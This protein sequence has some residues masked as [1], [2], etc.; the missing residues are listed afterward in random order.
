SPD[1]STNSLF[2]APCPGQ[3]VH[4]VPG[5]VW[6]TYAYH[7]HERRTMAWTLEGIDGERVRLRAKQCEGVL[8]SELEHNQGNCMECERLLTSESLARFVQQAKGDALPRTPW[9]YLNHYQSSKLMIDMSKRISRLYKKLR[10]TQKMNERLKSK[11]DDY[12]RLIML[13]SQH[14]IGGV[15]TILEIGIRNGASP[16]ALYAKLERAINGLYSPRS[17]WTTREFDIAFLATA[18]GGARLLYVFQKADSYPSNA[19]LKRRKPIPEL[20]VSTGIPNDPE[21]SQNLT[22]I[23]GEGG[24]RAP[25]NPLIGQTLMIDG[26]ALEEACRYDHQRGCI[27]GICREHAHLAPRGLRVQDYQHILDLSDSLYDEP[28]ACHHGK[29]G[30]VL[31]LAPVTGTK[32]YYPTP[33]L[34][35]PSCKKETGDELYDW[36]VRFLNI[37]RDHLDGEKKHGPIFTLATDGESSF[38]SMRYRLGVS[39]M[40]DIDSPMGQIV[41]HLPGFNCFT[42]PNGI[43]TTSDPKHIV[44]RFA[45]MIRSKK[46]IQVGDTHLTRE[47]FKRALQTMS[48]LSEKQADA[49]LNPADKQNVPLA[50]S[51]LKYLLEGSKKA[52]PPS[53]ELNFPYRLRKIRFLL[54]FLSYFLDP[55]INTEMTLSEQLKSLS[56]YSHLL[57]AMHLKHRASFMNT[58]LFADS[59]SVVKNVFYTAARLQLLDP[60]IDYHILFEGSDRL[61]GIFSNVRTQDHARNFDVLQLAHKL[62]VGAEINA[63][64]ERNPDLYQGH[65]RRNM[66]GNREGDHLNPKSWTGNVKVGDVD[67][68]SSYLTGRGDADRLL[69]EFCDDLNAYSVDW[70]TLFSTE[71]QDHLR[72]DGIYVGSRAAD[73]DSD[74]QE[75][76]DSD[77]QRLQGGLASEVIS[78]DD[79]LEGG[80]GVFPNVD[81]NDGWEDVP[82]VNRA[83]SQP[84]EAILNPTPPGTHIKKSYLDVGDSKQRHIDSIVAERLVSDRARKSIQRN[85]RVRDITINESIQR[86]HE[87]N[88]PDGLPDQSHLV[89]RGDL[90]A[91]LVQLPDKVCLAVGEVLFFQQGQKDL[92]YINA[93]DLVQDS[94][95][96]KTSITAQI[97]HLTLPKSQ[98]SSSTEAQWEWSRKYMCLQTNKEGIVSQKSYTIR[99]PG[100]RFVP[101]TPTVAADP[102]NQH[103][104]TWALKHTD[105]IAV[106]DDCWASLTP[107]DDDFLG[108]L[109]TIPK[110][111]TLDAGLPYQSGL[112]T[113]SPLVI[114]DQSSRNIPVVKLNGGARVSCKICATLVKLKE[115]RHHVGSQH[116]LLALR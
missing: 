107:D 32:N 62:S 82:E 78:N 70:T 74:P 109:A 41:Y 17:G 79:D 46:G 13:L 59:Q 58:A 66:Q 92:Q 73:G 15:S 110:V 115:M 69:A 19:T 10:N 86:V 55:F 54:T 80:A 112:G 68:I 21:I 3:W 105:L 45:S 101:L 29:D 37:Y 27:L 63:V 40:I 75:D 100:R 64:F 51:L 106:M 91:F 103:I 8:Q 72:P 30:T 22:S 33:V 35:S 18:L 44:K 9:I 93:N 88:D 56:T 116:I 28:P 87:L 57:T 53:T 60:K 77:S 96:K 48:G 49:L 84:L 31:A 71:G 99:I 102:S 83:Q 61:E 4:W 94:G 114:A 24:R 50:V 67:I 89:K 113:Y 39:E 12:K 7:Q 85:L 98:P 6:D 38:R 5:S 2:R 81:D 47:D 11:L 23:L 90:G 1:R 14:K 16:A 76:D 36:V 34:L 25:D 42:G 20:L 95:P 104:T 97:L 65:K 52:L 111:P 26:V 108:N 43:A